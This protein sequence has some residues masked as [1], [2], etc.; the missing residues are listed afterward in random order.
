M[1]TIPTLHY[2]FQFIPTHTR[3]VAHTVFVAIFHGGLAGCLFVIILFC[4]F[5]QTGLNSS[6]AVLPTL[7]RMTALYCSLGLSC[8]TVLDVWRNCLKP[9]DVHNVLDFI[10]NT[11]FYNKP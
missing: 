10:N 7:S 1:L 4:L 2:V 3:T 6:Y 5:P 9:F 8:R 11:N